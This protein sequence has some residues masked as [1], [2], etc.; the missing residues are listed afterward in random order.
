MHSPS[1]GGAALPETQHSLL[2]RLAELG[3]A[4]STVSHPPLFTVADSKALRGQL[5]GLH[6]KNLFLRPAAPGPYLLIT[7]EEDRQ[8]SINALTRRLGAGRSRFAAPEA[9]REVLGVEP[10]SVTPLAL[11]N[12]PPGSVRPV[13]DR[14]LAE[15]PGPVNCHPLTNTA[16]TALAP[17][18]L[19]RFLRELG[20]APEILDLDTVA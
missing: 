18:D 14:R 19:L 20:H 15:G 16:T 12:A 3:I 8:V 6:V 2:A 10:G 9:L 1:T 4:C 7:L 5:S 11:V 17:Q 13:I